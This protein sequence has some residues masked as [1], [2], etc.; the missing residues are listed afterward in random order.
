ME[1]DKYL[2]TLTKEG[3]F[4]DNRIRWKNQDAGDFF[5]SFISKMNMEFLPEYEKVILW[6]IENNGKGIIMYG[7]NG[8]GK[9]L[10][11]NKIL[12]PFFDFT[13]RKVVNCYPATEINENLEF[14]LTRKIVI[15]DDIGTE[16]QRVVFGDRKWSFAEIMD[17]AEQKENIVIVTT[18]LTPE[19]IEKKYG[20]R[21]RERVRAI[22]TPVLFKGDSMRK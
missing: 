16:D 4:T 6:M 18:N 1:I 21:T 20:L 8:R 19:T 3:F 15:L 22:C 7:S 13:M 5:K 10:I 9:S 12:P 14:I 2:D 11:A 17:R